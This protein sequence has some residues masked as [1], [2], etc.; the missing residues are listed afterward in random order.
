MSRV[1]FDTYR[2]AFNAFM[3]CVTSD[4]A[5]PQC[6]AGW[7]AGVASLLGDERMRR[8]ALGYAEY[9]VDMLRANGGSSA[10]CLAA[11]TAGRDRSP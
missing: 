7:Q 6:A 4:A 9:Y 2:G 5:P 3:D 1:Q 11:P 8:M 10:E